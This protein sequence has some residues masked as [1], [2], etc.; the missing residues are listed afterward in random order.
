MIKFPQALQGILEFINSDDGNTNIV[1]IEFYG[2]TIDVT[3]ELWDDFDNFPRQKWKFKCLNVK[4]YQ[5]QPHRSI[6]LEIVSEHPLLYPYNTIHSELFFN[7]STKKLKEL[8]ADLIKVHIKVVDEWF[9][10][11]NFV[12]QIPCITNVPYATGNDFKYGLFAKGPDIIMQ[13]YAKLLA[14]YNIPAHVANQHEPKY[15]DGS[16]WVESKKDNVVFFI[17]KNYIITNSIQAEP[18]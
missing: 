5:F 3:I 14:E 18:I 16:M 12:Y 2:N 13:E 1:S 4:S 15:W 11:E 9:S 6:G 17:G 10:L 7:G 8:L